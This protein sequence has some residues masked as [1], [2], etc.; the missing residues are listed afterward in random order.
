[1]SIEWCRNCSGRGYIVENQ[2]RHTT[3]GGAT[4]EPLDATRASADGYLNGHKV[5]PRCHG[6][7][8]IKFGGTDNSIL[9]GSLNDRP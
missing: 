6:F 8:A 1:M 5:C 3:T 2:S 9:D 7:G 4:A